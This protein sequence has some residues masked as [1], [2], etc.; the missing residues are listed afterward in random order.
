MRFLTMAAGAFAIA[1]FALPAQADDLRAVD[2]INGKISLQG[3]AT[4]ID[5][6]NN[7]SDDRAFGTIEGILSAP[8]GHRYGA[9]LDVATGFIDGY[10]VI[11]VA[12]HFFRRN[13]EIGLIGVTAQYA[14]LRGANVYRTGMEGEY[15]A[16]RWTVTGRAGYQWGT[17]ARRGRLTAPDGPYARATLDY[18]ITEDLM[19]RGGLGFNPLRNDQVNPQILGRIEWQFARSSVPGLT[20][21]VDGQV[22]GHDSYRAMAGIR[23]HFRLSGET[24]KSLIRRHREDDPDGLNNDVF[25]GGFSNGENNDPQSNNGGSQCPEGFVFV[26]GECV[27]EIRPE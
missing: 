20:A 19:I 24:D 9:Q 1:A 22:S 14:H 23:W 26:R 2:G 3:G 7:D 15:Y 21:F 8:L 4:Q 17:M 25:T 12:G 18:Y 27:P 11:G 6:L 13:P 16:G 5:G 10:P